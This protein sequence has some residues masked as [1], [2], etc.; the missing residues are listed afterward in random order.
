M[1]L[2]ELQALERRAVV[3][4]YVRNP[5]EFVRGQGV[6]LWDEEGNELEEGESD[7]IKSEEERAQPGRTSEDEGDVD[8]A[9]DVDREE[10]T[11][12]AT[13]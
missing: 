5:V 11:S 4:T 13:A 3:G 12:G 8:E 10:A 9:E 7:R 6:S 2:Q 1:S